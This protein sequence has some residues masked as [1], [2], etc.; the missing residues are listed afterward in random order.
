MSLPQQFIDEIN[1][2]GAPCLEGLVDALQTT[3]PAVSIRVNRAKGTTPPAGCTPVEWCGD[4][5][6][7]ESR[8]QF[9]FDPALHQGR[10]YVQDASSMAIAHVIRTILD[11]EAQPVRYLDACAAPGGKTTAAISALPSGSL[12][13]ANEYDYRR[14]SVLA[15]NLAKWGSP[16]VI[17]SRGDTS[18][19]TRLAD[20]FDIIAADV[21][22]SGEGMMRKDAEAVAQ[23]SPSLVAECVDRQ[24]EIVDNLWQA[25]RPGG[26]LIYSTCTFNRHENEE[27]VDYI[28]TELGGATVD[29]GLNAFGGVAPAIGSSHRC[30]RFIPGHIRGEGLFMSVIRKDGDSVASEPKTSKKPLTA[31]SKV[32]VEAHKTLDWLEGDFEP[33]MLGDRIVALPKAEARDIRAISSWLDVISA[34]IVVA[35]LK[36]RD[37]ILSQELAMSTACRLSSFPSVELDYQ[38]AVAYLRRENISVEAPKCFVLLTYEGHPL[39]FVKN[40]GNRANNLYPQPWRIIS[41]NTPDLP[42]S[43]L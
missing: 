19:F 24:R 30:Y 35:T 33:A 28:C 14:A 29:V 25:L 1:S 32:P 41:P 31:F 2:Y 38:T 21:P 6:Y 20:C 3:Q 18:R 34:G 36:G 37:I 11:E 4:G 40:L 43:V 5:V 27:M 8:P 23:W 22:C 12:V 10:Y 26:Y 9:T 15:E 42:P 16:D 39:G 17:V 13:V 7:L